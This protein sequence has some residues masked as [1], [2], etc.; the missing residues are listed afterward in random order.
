[1]IGTTAH[2]NSSAVR[3]A[4]RQDLPHLLDIL[5]TEILTST[6]SWTTSTRMLT[7]MSA[8]FDDRRSA[9]FP[10]LVATCR[11]EDRI[12]G[13]AS[14]GAFRQGEGYTGT[15][16]HSVYV[17]RDYRGRGIATSL[18]MSL[19]RA[20]KAAGLRLMIGGIS[21]DQ[22]ASLALHRKLGFREVGRIKG[23]GEK[24]GRTLDL[25]LMARTPV[26]ERE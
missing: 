22:T 12:A 21:A 25:V 13:Y 5:N 14:Y 11:N 23:A 6:A 1:M 18:V 9:G 3:A 10:V 7:E 17:H 20:A 19:L 2:G 16:E 4:R 8:W 24:F 15:V 26:D